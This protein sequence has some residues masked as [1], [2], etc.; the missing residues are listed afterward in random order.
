MGRQRVGELS[1][2]LDA[3]AEKIGSNS[4]LDFGVLRNAHRGA[5]VCGG[6]VDQPR[7]MTV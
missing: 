6:V 7:L 5:R 1:R 4:W 3:V 2:K